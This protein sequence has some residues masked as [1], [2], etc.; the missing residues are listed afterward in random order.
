MPLRAFLAR[1]SSARC[2]LTFQAAAWTLGIADRAP[3]R[4]EVAAATTDLARQL[5]GGVAA[6]VFDPRLDYMHRHDVPVLAPESVF[7]HMSANPRA[8]RSWSS[9]LEWLPD[10]AAAMSWAQLAIELADRVTTIR[11][12]TGYL[13]QALRPDLAEA[14]RDLGPLRGK[15]WFGPRGPLRRHDNAWQV[16]DTILPVDPRTLKAVR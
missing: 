9:A 16:A 13:V 4:I 10:I 6:S 14:I 12:R 7:V 15:T 5:P 11:V 3:A 1:Q 2:A 8:V